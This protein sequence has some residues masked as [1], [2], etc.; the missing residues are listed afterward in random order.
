MAT[1]SANISPA[2]TGLSIVQKGTSFQVTN[3]FITWPRCNVDKQECGHLLKELLD[4][5]FLIVAEEAH[6]DGTPHLHAFVKLATRTRVYH[7]EL[8]LIVGKHGNYQRARSVLHCIRYCAKDDDYY[9]DGIEVSSYLEASDASHSAK[10]TLVFNMIKNGSTLKQVYD[11]YPDFAF[12]NKAKIEDWIEYF[13]ELEDTMQ[14]LEEWPMERLLLNSATAN[15]QDY[16]INDWLSKNVKAPRVLGQKHLYIWGL[17][18]LG[19][20]GLY[21]ALEN[22]LTIYLMPTDKWH[23]LYENKKYDLVVCDD[24]KGDQPLTFM[25]KFMDGLHLYLQKKGGGTIYRD[26]LPMI[27]FANLQPKDIYHRCPMVLVEAFSRRFEIVH[28]T[29][30]IHIF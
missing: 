22:Y 19:K 24:F 2:I 13:V 7:E 4:P 18:G 14:E 29:E 12:M 26:F 17:T 10:A 8:D 11:I 9:C 21:H 6:A 5:L 1:V 28:V 25:N 15:P 27:V 16:E 30:F 23:P 3:L 20:T